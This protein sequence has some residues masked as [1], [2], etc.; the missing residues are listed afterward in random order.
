MLLKFTSSADGR[1]LGSNAKSRSSKRR[2]KGSAL[3]N[4]CENGTGDFLRM[5][6]KYLLAFSFRICRYSSRIKKMR[7]CTAYNKRSKVRENKRE[8]NK[9]SYA[10]TGWQQTR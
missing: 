3:G 9:F 7:L 6:L 10:T 4:F 1:S 5:L 2:A 8:S